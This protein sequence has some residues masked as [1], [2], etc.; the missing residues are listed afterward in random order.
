[1]KIAGI[2]VFAILLVMANHAAAAAPT[3]GCH[4]SS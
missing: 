3:I 2:I 4:H 1:M